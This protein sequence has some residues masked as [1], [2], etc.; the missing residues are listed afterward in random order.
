MVDFKSLKQLDLNSQLDLLINS[1]KDAPDVKVAIE[2]IKQEGD[3]PISFLV[4]N[5]FITNSINLL[6]YYEL[7]P[8]MFAIVRKVIIEENINKILD[9][10]RT[11][12]QQLKESIQKLQKTTKSQKKKI[13]KMEEYYHTTIDIN[14]QILSNKY[15]NLDSKRLK[16][17]ETITIIN[18]KVESTDNLI[19]Q[20]DIELNE[21]IKALK[22]E[23]EVF[24][25]Y[26]S[27]SNTTGLELRICELE[28]S[29]NSKPSKPNKSNQS[30]QKVMNKLSVI[31][32]KLKKIE[33]DTQIKELQDNLS[34]ER[35]EKEQLKEEIKQLKIILQ[36]QND[37]QNNKFQKFK[38]I[39]DDMNMNFV[40]QQSVYNTQIKELQDKLD[41]SKDIKDKDKDKDKDIN[42]ELQKLK[43]M[44][45]SM[46]MN[47]VKQQSE[48]NRV[49]EDKIITIVQY[50]IRRIFEEQ[51]KLLVYQQQYQQYQQ[52]YP[53]V[54]MNMECT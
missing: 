27:K 50:N 39:L 21:R 41:K 31:D 53:V 47:F 23:I 43:N 36:N 6:K 11:S 17:D 51:Q 34:I 1:I 12:I 37:T 14:M 49:N 18:K 16:Q 15:S 26:I 29:K 2:K 4:S 52:E 10:N 30:N 45:D 20:N 54:S 33:D 22:N 28:E 19:K 9:A 46:N 48:N 5:A 3:N 35:T 42:K 44:L 13:D 25:E 38:K 24:R 8:M 7:P 40:K 32:T